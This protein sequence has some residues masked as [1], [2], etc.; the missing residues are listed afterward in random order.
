MFRS[1]VAIP[2]ALPQIAEM[3]RQLALVHLKDNVRESCVKE[4]NQ[5]VD[6]YI[7]NISDRKRAW[8]RFLQIYSHI[9]DYEYERYGI[10]RATI[11]EYNLA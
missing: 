4:F 11:Y 10:N 7:K 8:L 1:A 2:Q 6:E 3:N 5:A 9:L